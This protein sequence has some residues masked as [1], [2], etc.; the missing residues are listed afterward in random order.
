ML[1]HAHAVEAER[2]GLGELIDVLVVVDVRFGRIEQLVRDPD[3]GGIVLL[4]EIGGQIAVRHQVEEEVLHEAPPA[5]GG[6]SGK[7]R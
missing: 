5:R 4:L 1:V 6:S 2:L 7:P 3:P